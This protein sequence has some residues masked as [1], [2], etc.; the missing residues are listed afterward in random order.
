MCILKI[1]ITP[2][3]SIKCRY[4]SVLLR[5]G[6]ST[7]AGGISEVLLMVKPTPLLLILTDIP[8]ATRVFLLLT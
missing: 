4:Q 2:L 3:L 1:L 7:D 8:A 5:S 6:F